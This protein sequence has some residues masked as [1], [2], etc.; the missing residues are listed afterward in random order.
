MAAP[1]AAQG[2]KIGV[3]MGSAYIFTEE[4]VSTGAITSGFQAEALK[5]QQTIN[6]ETGPGHASRC[7]FTSF[8]QEFDDTRRQMIVTG[9]SPDEIKETLENLTLGRLRI[10]SKGLKRNAGSMITVNSEQQVREGMY[11]IGQVAT[12]RSKV[13]TLKELHEDVS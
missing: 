8:A 1:L 11:M 13:C 2:I 7:A 9:K 6:L 3:L 4:A 10:A 5:C 12:L